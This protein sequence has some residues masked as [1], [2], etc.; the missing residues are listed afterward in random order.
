MI[1]L[2]AQLTLLSMCICGLRHEAMEHYLLRIDMEWG[3]CS[4]YKGL[5]RFLGHPNTLGAQPLWDLLTQ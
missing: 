4:I 3:D 5:N 1:P 2:L